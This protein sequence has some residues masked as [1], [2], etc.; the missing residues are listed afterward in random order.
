MLNDYSLFEFE[1]SFIN[2]TRLQVVVSTNSCKTIVRDKYI[3]EQ[4]L[5]G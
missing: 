2:I 3:G 4:V 1:I 5:F